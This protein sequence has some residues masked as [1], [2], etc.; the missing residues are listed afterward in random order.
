VSSAASAQTDATCDGTVRP[1]VAVAFLG[2][3]WAP[4]LRRGVLQ[5]LAAGLRL[6]GIDT[7]ALGR[8]GKKPPLAVV[9]LDAGE[10]ERVSVGIEIYDALT[11][12]RVIREVDLRPLAADARALAI[13]AAADELLRASWAELALEDAPPP[14]EPPPPEVQRVLRRSIA[15]AKVGARDRAVGLRGALDLHG[16]GQTWLGADTFVSFWLGERVGLQLALGL[17]EGLREDAA[18]GRVESRALTG[19]GQL[20]LALLAR[21]EELELSAALGT[22]VASVRLAGEADA[23]GRDAEGSGVDVHARAGLQLHVLALAWLGL[24]AELCSGLPLRSVAARDDGREV[25]STGGPSLHAS[26]GAEVVF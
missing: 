16:G 21:G 3:R 20:L 4:E 23:G 26:L 19:S 2:S 15:P 5:D 14:S 1:W 17:R 9:E 18:H 22:Q 7:C 8:E 6:K 11:Q 24:G 10:Q 13:A 25:T 12:K